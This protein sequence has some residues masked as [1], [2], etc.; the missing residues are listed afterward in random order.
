MKFF[1]AQLQFRNKNG[2]NIPIKTV[3][4]NQLN[5]MFSENKSILQKYLKEPFVGVVSFNQTSEHQ[6][7]EELLKKLK[8]ERDGKKGYKIQGTI[9]FDNRNT[10]FDGTILF[11]EKPPKSGAEPQEFI[12]P[13][14]GTLEKFM[15]PSVP[16]Q[17]MIFS[18]KDTSQQSFGSNVFGAPT[19][20]FKALTEA[21]SMFSSGPQ[22][23][24]SFGSAPPPPTSEFGSDPKPSFG[25]APPTSGFGTGQARPTSGFG[26]GSKPSFGYDPQPP[27][28]S[29]GLG[30]A[31]PTTGFGSG[32]ARPTT[33]FGTDSKPSFGYDPQPPTSGFG[34]G[35]GSSQHARP[36]TFAQSP[37]KNANQGKNQNKEKT[38]FST[39]ESGN[40]STCDDESKALSSTNNSGNSHKS[41]FSQ[42]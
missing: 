22:S 15:L 5:K 33:G 16:P 21:N 12:L 10:P 4:L 30:H 38:L 35:I 24:P 42:F 14:Y 31:R 40:S 25:S 36:R 8:I 28:S 29:F 11:F 27:T 23:T 9:T 34:T 18:G 7:H 3:F 1:T 2:K 17:Q 19:G 20:G 26:S 39:C 32:H 37:P 41:V 6:Q 13:G